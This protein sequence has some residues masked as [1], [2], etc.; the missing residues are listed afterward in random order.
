MP[1][2]KN[3]TFISTKNLK[4]SQITHRKKNKKNLQSTLII[5]L[6]KIKKKNHPFIHNRSIIF[7]VHELF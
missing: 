6:I 4:I 1:N 7:F 5:N 2:L 3:T